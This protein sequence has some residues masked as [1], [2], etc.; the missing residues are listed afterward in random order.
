MPV[1]GHGVLS[2]TGT[3]GR[4]ASFLGFVGASGKGGH[5]VVGLG[6]TGLNF[7]GVAL[8]L[9]S[10]IF[11]DVGI[12]VWE[13]RPELT[14]GC[15]NQTHLTL[16]FQKGFHFLNDCGMQMKTCAPGCAFD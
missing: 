11:S 6:V 13:W 5:A 8:F 4:S 12:G 10:V 2:C 3:D 1:P 16:H 7:L 9:F 14:T 15:W